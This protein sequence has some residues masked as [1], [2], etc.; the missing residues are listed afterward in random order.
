[1]TPLSRD[2]IARRVASALPLGAVVNLGIGLPGLVSRYVE[3]AQD[4]VLHSENGIINFAA[5]PD[6]GTADHDSIDASKRPVTVLPGGSYL[7]V[8]LSFGL[9]RGGHLDV[10][11]LGAFE[12]S[13]RGDLAN[14]WT[15]QPG[16]VPGVG[17]AMD[18][19][20]GAKSIWV[21]M[22]HTTR[23]GLPKLVDRCS[24]PLTAPAVV[25]RIFTDLAVLD[26]TPEGLCVRE[27]V[28]G[29][30]PDELQAR[31]A[32]RLIFSDTSRID[33]RALDRRAR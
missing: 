23:D 17:G 30:K 13:A 12:V 6:G 3:A 2:D 7:D 27:L 10:A 21:M 5:S 22:E 1:M 8:A 15:G 29:L 16:D 14:W 4:I 20:C 33:A 18:L 32:T 28:A 26:V 25:D 9:M 11:V 31:T 19:A 24:Y